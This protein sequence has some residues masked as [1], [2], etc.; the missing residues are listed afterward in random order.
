M[1]YREMA[2]DSTQ[3]SSGQYQTTQANFGRPHQEASGKVEALEVASI[4]T[5]SHK[6]CHITI[7]KQMEL[8]V[9]SQGGQPKEV[10]HMMSYCPPP[11]IPH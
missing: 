1:A 2:H 8:A 7:Q 6:S 3:P 11:Y 9:V 10:Y 4:R 5:H